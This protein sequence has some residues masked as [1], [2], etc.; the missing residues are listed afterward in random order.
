M[1]TACGLI[2]NGILRALTA[3]VFCT[4][5]MD[6]L[7]FPADTPQHDEYF[8]YVRATLENISLDSLHSQ[9]ACCLSGLQS[10]L[11]NVSPE[12]WGETL[13]PAVVEVGSPAASHPNPTCLAFYAKSWCA[14]LQ[15]IMEHQPYFT[16]YMDAAS[17]PS[18]WKRT[19]L[20]A[21][22]WVDSL[23]AKPV[24]VQPTVKGKASAD[25]RSSPGKAKACKPKLR[26]K[27][28]AGRTA[29]KATA[30]KKTT[31]TVFL[32]ARVA[33]EA[34]AAATAETETARLPKARAQVPSLGGRQAALDGEVP[35]TTKEACA[36]LGICPAQISSP[37]EQKP[38]QH[39]I[40][41]AY[42]KLVRKHH[43]DKHI[44]AEKDAANERFLRIS[45][46]Y[47]LLAK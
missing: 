15:F 27:E 19:A 25:R 20:D 34:A 37:L 39:I 1:H 35:R 28:I 5:Q 43:P 45:A 21:K 41:K 13:Q 14:R 7:C 8:F 44:Q 24:G 46:A 10:I 9:G 29:S 30:K 42:L 47:K 31:S 11:K 16:E 23:R 6:R 3:P 22:R 38:S 2:S 4:G 33:A 17:N 36:V 18:T 32:A 26:R 12:D 40:R